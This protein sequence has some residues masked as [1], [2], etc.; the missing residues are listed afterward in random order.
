MQ[1]S[2]VIGQS[3]VKEKL[4]GLFRQN[5]V[6]HALL[7]LG[8]EGTG[9]MPL[10]RAFAQY[11][12][13][14]K[15]NGSNKGND[16]FGTNEDVP[17]DDA[18]DSCG[19]CPSCM[20]ATGMVHPD[21]HYSFPTIKKSSD[22]VICADYM[23]EWRSFHQ[24]NPYGNIFDWLQHIEAENKQGNITA[25]ECNDIARK[26]NLK[27]FESGLKILV[28]WMPEYLGK[29]GNKLLKLIEE[30]PDK[31]VFILVAENENSILPTILSRTQLIKVPPVT[32]VEMETSLRSRDELTEQ[33]VSRVVAWSNGNYHRALELLQQGENENEPLLREWMNT[34]LKSGPAAQIKWIDEIGK[35]GRE[36]QKHFLNFFLQQV[37]SAIRLSA[38]GNSASATND[39]A[40]RLN[41]LCSVHQLEAISEELTQSV[42]QIE[43]NAHARILFH[44]L[45]IRLY[46]I[47]GNNSVILLG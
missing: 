31:T 44:A 4:T 7:F 25:A 42:Y 28:M 46:H 13:C 29:E 26:L 17:S 20:K 39:F 3:L 18:E 21:I 34:I 41:K 37:E 40:L 35:W 6:S 22:T 16:L 45:T 38:F 5:R 27:S 43:R 14:E 23:N 19:V 10:A 24:T 1:F 8:R 9:G 15:I 12:V 11:L 2:H 47:I 30:P 33:Q 32:D 36:Q